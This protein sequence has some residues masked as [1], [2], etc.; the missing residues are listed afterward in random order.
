MWQQ[1]GE[2]QMSRLNISCV[3]VSI[4]HTNCYIVVNGDTNEGFIVDPGADAGKIISAAEKTGAD[5]KAVLLTHGHFD[6]IGAAGECAAHFHALIYAAEAEKEMLGDINLN[7]GR[8][9]G[10]NATA[11]ADRF[12]KDGQVINVCKTDIEV[13]ATPGHTKGGVCYY[14][15]EDGVL[16]SGDTLFFESYGR[17]DLPTADGRQLFESIKNRLFA[18]DDE[19][20]VLSGHGRSTSIGYEKKNNPCHYEF[21]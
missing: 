2:E 9:F 4:A 1:K 8:L 16:F 12:V 10:V 5:I 7:A 6:H 20:V 21:Y 13:I 15:K 11:V 18:L 14:L 19:I 17:Y 3:V